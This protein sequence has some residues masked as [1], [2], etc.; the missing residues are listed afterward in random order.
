MR[1]LFRTIDWGFKPYLEALELQ[2]S[3]V[4]ARKNEDIENTIIFTEHEP[5]Y[6]LGSRIDAIK[7]LKVSKETLE[8]KQ[9]PIYKTNR[10]G[11]ITFHGPGQL[12]SLIHI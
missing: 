2:K 8:R 7:N 10:G 12:L 6:T 3:M 9:V 5:V 1:K 4:E 11:D